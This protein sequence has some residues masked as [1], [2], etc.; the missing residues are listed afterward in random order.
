MKD[1]NVV[2]MSNIFRVGPEPTRVEQISSTSLKGGLLA[3]P[4]NIRLGWKGLE[5]RHDTQHKGIQH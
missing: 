5:E 3:S 4:A 1:S 2:D